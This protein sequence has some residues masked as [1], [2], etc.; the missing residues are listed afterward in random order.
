MRTQVFSYKGWVGI[1]SDVTAEG[2][3]NKPLDKGQLG[4]VIDAAFVDI[5]PE[6]L[7][8]LK[9]V[10]KSGDCIGDV[11]IIKSRDKVLFLWLGSPLKMFKPEQVTGSK[12]YDAS[13]ITETKE[14]VV[15]PAFIKVVDEIKET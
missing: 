2:L 12:E 11:D 14:T 13:L 4:F 10:K 7:D 8:L 1:Q 6:A 5:S 3:L 9:Q 15:D